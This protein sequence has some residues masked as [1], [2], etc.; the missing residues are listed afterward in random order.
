M[1]GFEINGEFLDLPDNPSVE[2]QR[3]STLFQFDGFV[4]GNFTLPIKFPNTPKNK[5]LFNFPHIV[6]NASRLRPKWT[7]RLWYNGVPRLSGEIRAKNP[8]N[9]NVIT[10]NFVAG[11]SLIGDDIKVR[12]LAEVI[13]ETITIHSQTIYKSITIIFNIGGTYKIKVNGNEYNET[14]FTTLISTINADPAANYT[15]SGA[16][17]VLTLT[18][19]DP[20][21]FIPF[22]VEA[23]PDSNAVVSGVLPLWMIDY[24]TAY[25][26]F[27]TDHL[28]TARDDKKI[29]FGTWGNK[30]EVPGAVKD[31]PIINYITGGI[32][33]ANQYRNAAVPNSEMENFSSLA[34]ALTIGAMIEAIE[35]YYGITINF[36]ALD[37]DDVMVCP[38][39]LDVPVKFFNGESLI[40]YQRSFN[41][42]QIV[43]DITVNEFL[44]ALQVGFN[45]LVDFDP[46]QKIL[47]IAHRQPFITDRTYE[48]ITEQCS[49]PS[50]VQLAIKKGLRF[51]LQNDGKDK[52][53]D[54]DQ[55]PS[56]YLVDEGE[57]TIQAGFGTYGMR[58]HTSK[59]DWPQDAA[60]LTLWAE[61]P[62]DTKFG[63]RFA[64]YV[65][66]D[67][68]Y[69]DSRP[70]LWEATGGLIESYWADSISL[71]NNPVTISTTWRMP[72][73]DIFATRWGKRWRIDR[74][75]FL[76]VDFGVTLRSNGVS[77]ADCLFVQLPTFVD[78]EEPV[79]PS[80]AWRVLES[81]LR[82]ERDA[83]NINTGMAI[84]DFLEEYFTETDLPTGETKLN[85]PSDPDYVAPVEDF[86]S[87][88]VSFGG[89]TSG[90]L[91][92][93]MNPAI[94][95]NEEKVRINGT[96]YTLRTNG[97]NPF[98]YPYP[99]GA[100]TQVD[101]V[102][103]SNPK[104]NVYLW[105]V[106]VYQNT[107]K[108]YEATRT[109]GPNN[110]GPPGTDPIN[111]TYRTINLGDANFDETK[112]NRVIITRTLI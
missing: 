105:K 67:E 111:L 75:D 2:L 48:D 42:N 78:G 102:T 51:S 107:T 6:E 40:L 85:A 5:R 91:Y 49:E 34:P 65:D 25:E 59:A 1:I 43:P 26:D 33:Q 71:E 72:R 64:R 70:F 110:A 36:F 37:A 7:A 20:G 27:I 38:W 14:V 99:M 4:Q 16:S 24:K 112:I 103:A 54:A 58:T 22:Y 82:C 41:L 80:T 100:T 98:P 23:D 60:L 77:A 45:A 28:S 88:P 47:T 83:N 32:F 94:N 87:C 73:N 3:A 13:D 8:I 44:K 109:V 29:R 93:I 61:I 18:M 69:L 81:S 10:A 11:L 86:V 74:N 106:E 15:A 53:T 39:T 66:G 9:K 95:S 19:D 68:P 104:N 35:T 50:D 97:P 31:W 56:D 90:N 84:Y 76:L 101:I 89:Y 17:D 96:E 46:D 79:P 63:L 92:I 52:V 21:E 30:T 62:Y 55:T 108:I 57:R 12:K